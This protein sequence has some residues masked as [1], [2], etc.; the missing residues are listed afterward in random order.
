MP[1][2]PGA[3]KHM[4]THSAFVRLLTSMSPHMHHQHVLSFEG[5]LLPGAIEPS[6][7]KLLLLTVDM[8][9]IDMLEWEKERERWKCVIH[10]IG[11]ERN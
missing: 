9:V 1:G 11:N 3:S 5:F 6:A 2:D 4:G 7:H 8:V 10:F